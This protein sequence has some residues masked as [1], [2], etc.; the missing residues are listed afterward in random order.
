MTNLEFKNEFLIS[1]NAIASNSAPGIDDYELSVYLTR[2]QLEIVKNYYDPLSNRKQKGFEA[3]EKRRRDLNQLVKDYKTTDTILN[4]FNIDSL[5]KFYIVPNDLFL[6]VNEKA[7]VTSEDCYNSK[8]LTIKPMSYDEYDIQ[9]DN[10]FEKPNEKIA[11]RLDLSNVNNV[12]VVEIISPYNILGS[13]EYQIRYIKYPK[14]IIITNLNT[15]FPS[16][17]LTIDGI[18]AETPCEL[19]AEICREILDRAVLLALADYRPQNLQV[20]AQ[21]SQTNE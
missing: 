11:W 13:L 18:F 17:N 19:N 14:P 7:K 16:D 12:K 10:P 1:Y 15:T 5:A 21:M 6:I 8:T 3:T 9:I 20:K 2:A 4:D